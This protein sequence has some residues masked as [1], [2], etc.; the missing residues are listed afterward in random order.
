MVKDKAG[1]NKY[2][3]N[4]NAVE[5]PETELLVESLTNSGDGLGRIDQRVVF[6]PYTMPGDRVQIKIR[7]RKKTYIL[8]DK[9]N[10]IEPSKERIPAT[11]HYFEQC[12]GCDWQHVPYTLQLEAK[13]QQLQDTL[14]RIG[15]LPELPIETI[16]ASPLILAYRNRIQGEIHGGNF[17]YKRK[18]SDQPIAIKHCDIAGDAINE[19]LQTDLSQAP[20]GRVEIA[21]IDNEV[22][23]LP[24][25]DQNSTELGFRQVN[26]GISDELSKHI[27]THL[28]K[29][30]STRVVDLYCGRGNWTNQI[31]RQHPEKIVIGVDSSSDN[32]KAASE[33]ARR[34]SLRNVTYHTAAVEKLLKKLELDESLCIV[35]PPRAGLAPALIEALTNT[36]CSELIYVSCHPATLARDLQ[37]LTQ[38]Q[39]RVETLVPMDMFPHTAHLECLV[40]LIQVA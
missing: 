6:V 35:D 27:L 15:K 31:A 29:S 2:R 14:T 30:S 40:K 28:G 38:S 24:V 37:L 26:T 3:R 22:S 11:C 39:Y 13:Q 7:Q 4:K 18:R 33:S 1:W 19:F 9:V 21:S 23:V 17:H 25:N 16:V 8:A 20:Q 32:I 36:P 10:L 5:L 12:G 34:L